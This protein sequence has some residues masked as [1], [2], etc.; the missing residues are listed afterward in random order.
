MSEARIMFKNL[1]FLG[2]SY[3]KKYLTDDKELLTQ[4]WWKAL[5]FFFRHSFMRGR[6]DVLSYQYYCFA[7]DRLASFLQINDERTNECNSL[8]AHAMGS[9]FDKAVILRFKRE[10]G[11]DGRKNSLSHKEFTSSVSSHHDLI[12]LLT[13]PSRVLVDWPKKA[14]KT[15]KLGNETDVTMLMDVLSFVGTIEDCNIYNAVRRAIIEGGPRE[16]YRPLVRLRGI[17]DKIASFVI[18]DIALM[19]P[20]LITKDYEVAF[21]IDTWVTKLSSKLGCREGS[22]LGIKEYFIKDCLSQGI[23]PLL[24]AAGIWYL[25]YNSLEILLDGFLSSTDF[26]VC[27]LNQR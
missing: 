12:R 11:M 26:R 3:C 22:L 21:P 4:D 23:D 25:G 7:R 15:I 10:K 6:N 17:D 24:L 20:G 5:L 9:D 18:R 1:E 8:R 14:Y 2:H 13:T 27:P 19:S 16:A